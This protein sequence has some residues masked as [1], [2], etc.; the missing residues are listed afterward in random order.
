MRIYI[1]FVTLIVIYI[2]CANKSTNDSVNLDPE[3][4]ISKKIFEEKG[5]DNSK[6]RNQF[7]QAIKNAGLN[8]LFSEDYDLKN[9]TIYENVYLKLSKKEKENYYNLLSDSFKKMVSHLSNGKLNPK[10]IYPDWEIKKN[11][12]KRDSLLLLALDSLGVKTVLANCE[13]QSNVYKSLKLAL[14]KINSLPNDTQKE[15]VTKSKFKPGD[16]NKT[17]V[18]I[19]KRLQ[20]WKDLSKNDSLTEKYDKNLE[21]AVK[22]FQVRHGL[23]ADGV[24][25]TGTLMALNIKKELRKQQI[26]CNLERWRWFPKQL[27]TNYLVVNI[28]NYKLHTVQHTDTTLTFRVV[29]GT[30]K[31]KTPILSSTV[32]EVI[33]NPTW[34]VPPT[35]I[36]EDLIPETRKS[37]KYIS[38]RNITIYNRK[39]KEVNL[40]DWHHSVAEDYKYVQK[41]GEDNALGF[42]KI[43]FPNNHMVYLHDTNHRELFVKNY[44][45]LSSGCVRVENPLRLAEYLLYNK[46]EIY[47][48]TKIDSIITFKE[49]KAV[50]I[51]EPFQVHILYFTAW[52][53]NGLLQFRDDVYAYDPELYLRLSNQ[54]TSDVVT[55]SGVIN[56]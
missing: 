39:G 52:Y 31:R 2:G 18:F 22:K 42:V 20:F 32:S 28:P 36:K 43:N 6:N 44:R 14:K 35:I 40:T 4:K 27:G 51:E 3:T 34:T 54:F 37:K 45:A 15:I 46:P 24:I 13:P 16:K 1:F 5:W 30:E 56:K 50:K 25:G 9:I 10:E 8:G 49:T 33:F 53:D 38:N 11:K 7:I 41:P 23:Q 47:N 21:I 19:K 48:A 26:I 17:I 29:V 55:T 12:V